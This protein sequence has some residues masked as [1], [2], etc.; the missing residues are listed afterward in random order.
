MWSGYSASAGSVYLTSEEQL[1]R[2]AYCIRLLP[3]PLYKK[4]RLMPTNPEAQ[5]RFAVRD[6]ERPAPSINIR[7]RRKGRGKKK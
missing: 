7:A 4:E 6:E 3:S 2:L 5:R 1:R